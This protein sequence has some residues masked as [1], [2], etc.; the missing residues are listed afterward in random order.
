MSKYCGDIVP[1]TRHLCWSTI[2]V[3][4]STII[5]YFY[6]TEPIS[7]TYFNRC[8]QETFTKLWQPN[9][10]DFRQIRDRIHM[11]SHNKKSENNLF[12]KIENKLKKQPTFTLYINSGNKI[13]FWPG[14]FCEL[15]TYLPI[16]SIKHELTPYLCKW[17]QK[18]RH[19]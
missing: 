19:K 1:N 10:M 6:S 9:T 14:M 16:T 15:S 12:M 7:T 11:H 2:L 8:S 17:S 3:P 4:V 18:N 13:V 5:E